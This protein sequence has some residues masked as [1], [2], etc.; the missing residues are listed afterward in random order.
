MSDIKP[1]L[2]EK[3]MAPAMSAWA[4]GCGCCAE[5]TPDEYDGYDEPRGAWLADLMLTAVA[6]DLRAEGA[7]RALREAA[8]DIERRINQPDLILLAEKYGS[9][10]AGERHRAQREVDI[11]RVRAD[12]IGARDG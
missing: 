10:H 5:P 6:D 2:I 4:I 12:R 1:E 8:N 7:E 11:L 9:F 3:A